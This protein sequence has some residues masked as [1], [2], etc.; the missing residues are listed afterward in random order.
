MTFKLKQLAWAAGAA[1]LLASQ[2]QAGIT[3]RPAIGI[4]TLDDSYSDN[5]VV[6]IP[7]DSP[8]AHV[9]PNLASSLFSGVVSINIRYS[10]G[11]YICSGTLVN[12]TQVVTAGH[13]VDT[14]GNGD[15]I[16][17]SQPFAVSGRDV[18]V[19]FNSNGTQ[20]AVMTAS[21][22]SMDPR[23]LGFGNCPPGNDPQ[24]FC[25]NNDIA[26]I[27]LGSAA[28]STAR[29]YPVAANPISGPVPI[30][31]VGYGTSGT[32]NTGGTISPSFQIKR[33]GQNYSEYYE[34]DS[35]QFFEG[36]PEGVWYAD[37]DGTANAQQNLFCTSSYASL[38]G[39]LCAPT[40]ANH[41]ESAIAGGDSGGAA[42][43]LVNG[44]YVLVGNTTFGGTMTEDEVDSTYGTFFGGIT[45]GSQIDY[46]L[47]A[48][49]GNLTLVT[50]PVPVPEPANVLLMALGLGGIGA[51]LRR[52]RASAQA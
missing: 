36:G 20:N 10:G 42:F 37:F 26:V 13:C 47:A 28:P 19:V 5:I 4:A 25:V 32:G 39:N 34:L 22:V 27:T 44:Q 48:T 6:G 3:Y 49:N 9:D 50:V 15:V 24:S 1:L 52:R 16:D 2:A 14:T 46:L 23:Y 11:S 12:S 31:M 41:L 8:A 40:L 38:W 43:M 29:I 7:P 45:T 35:Y 17:V 51:V 21:A 33:T 30:T 18:R